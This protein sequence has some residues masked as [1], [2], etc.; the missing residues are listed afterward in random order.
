MTTE[1][2]VMD[3]VGAVIVFIGP[4]VLIMMTGTM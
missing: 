3:L 4:I 1:R 2:F